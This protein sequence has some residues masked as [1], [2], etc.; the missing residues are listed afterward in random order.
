[1]FNESDLTNIERFN[2]YIKTI[3]NNEPMPPFSMDMTRDMEAEKRAAN[4]KVA[5]MIVQL[6]R[7]KHGR[8]KELVEEEIRV[9]SNL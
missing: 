5:D 2:V 4:K 6:S 1:V 7:L 9:R 8:D 3:M